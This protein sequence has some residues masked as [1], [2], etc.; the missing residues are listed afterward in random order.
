MAT[1][2]KHLETGSN[3][4]HLNLNNTSIEMMKINDSTNPEYGFMNFLN[5]NILIEQPIQ[6]YDAVKERDRETSMLNNGE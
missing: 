6:I 2:N 1:D 3:P 4:Y 5:Q